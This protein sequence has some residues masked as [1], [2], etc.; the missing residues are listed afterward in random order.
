MFGSEQFIWVRDLSEGILHFGDSHC[1]VYTF[2]NVRHLNVF[3][4][5]QG[6]TVRSTAGIVRCGSGWMTRY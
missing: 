5:T 3:L 2:S 6:I 4:D 1:T